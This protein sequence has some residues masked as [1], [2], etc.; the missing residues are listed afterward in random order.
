MLQDLKYAIRTLWGAKGWTSVVLVSLTLGI[1]ANTALFT[2]VNGVLLQRLAVADPDTL[3]R[4][5]WAGQN[6]MMR[7]SSEYGF[8]EPYQGLN[9]R[10]TFSF[11]QLQALQQVNQTLTDLF[12]AAPIGAL[13]VVI[14]GD[15]DIASSFGVTG[16][17]FRVLGLPAFIGRTLTDE[18]LM[19]GAP[20]AAVISHGFWRRRFASDPNVA[21][22]VVSINGQPVTIVGVTP[23]SFLGIQRLAGFAADVTVPLTLDPVFNV[24]QRRLLEPANWW[25]HL[26]GRLKPGVTVDQA[27]GNF[28]GVFQHSARAGMDAYLSGLSASERGL[29]SN[30]RRGTQV[31]ILLATSAAHGIYDFDTNSSRTATVLAA[32]VVMVLLMVC[33]NVANLLL[34]RA[35][36]RRKELSVRLSVG[37]TRLRLIR[38]LLTES[39][40][41]SGLGGALGILVA[42]WTRELVPFGQTAPMDWRVLGFVAALSILTAIIFGLVPAFRATRVD[43]AGAMKE[44]SRSISSARSLLAR[45]LVVAQVAMSLVL[46]VGAGLFLRTLGHLRD[47]DIGFN[48]HNLLMFNINPALNRYDAERTRQVFR[49]L[50]TEIGAIPGVRTMAF[51]RVALLSGSTSTSSVHIPGRAA[52]VDVHVMSVSP[53]FFATMEI[54]FTAGR[55][56]SD[57]DVSGAPPVAIINETAAR[58]LFP[59]DN[60]L[61]RR[62]GFELEKA[63]DIEVVGVIRDTKY[64]SLRDAPPPT[65]YQAFLQGTPRSMNVVIRTAGDPTGMVDTVRAVVRRVEPA[66]PLQ[67]LSTQTEHLERRVAQERLFARAY[68][69]FGALALTLAAV[70]L[71]GLM[72]YSVSRRT[73]EI[74]IRMALGADRRRVAGMVLGESLLLVGLGTSVGLVV[75]LASTRFVS[76]ILFGL[77]PTDLVTFLAA[78]GLLGTVVTLAAFLPARRASRVDPMHALRQQ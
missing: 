19:P 33:A 47:V 11:A 42:Y 70:G 41:L 76:A 35:S 10:A 78:V 3:V 20:A 26:V 9:V 39:L 21:G 75:A 7:G 17:Y 63:G 61:G 30:Q 66:L 45:A 74:G 60:P 24:G 13:N 25:V 31:P 52:P 71:F 48:P 73:N 36:A 77:A 44:T 46:L 16:A 28:E 49:E 29:A 69:L 56:F 12:A 2:A 68:T 59:D 38:Q 43:L 32:V 14:D 1:G 4:F 34:S 54:P 67:S 51:T 62:L 53:R 72:S 6:D 55:D 64:S 18:D 58:T 50:E 15:A 8:N 5:K 40:V 22:R 37:A 65:V 27:R 57:R 23:E